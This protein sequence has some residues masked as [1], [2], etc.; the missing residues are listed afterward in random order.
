MVL[1]PNG[2]WQ[3]I[4][5]STVFYPQSVWGYCHTVFLETDGRDVGADTSSLLNETLAFLSFFAPYGIIRACL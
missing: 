3:K 5:Q 2:S 4:R 1:V